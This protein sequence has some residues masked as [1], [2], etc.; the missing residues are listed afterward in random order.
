MRKA[1][2]PKG[3]PAGLLLLATS[4]FVTTAAYAQAWLPDKGRG[5]I[6]VGYQYAHAHWELLPIDLTDWTF[7]P[8]PCGPGKKC[9]DG[10]HYGQFVTFDVDYGIRQGLAMTAQLTW[11]ATQYK[12][13]AI[14]YV[15]GQTSLPTDNGNYHG[16]FQD[17]ELGVH[18]MVLRAPF[19]ATPFLAYHFPVQRYASLGHAA[20]GHH[21]RELRLGAA[22]ARTLTPFLPDV[23]VQ[24]TYAYNAAERENHHSLHRNSLDM[25]LGYFV[26]SKLSLKGAA[27]W[28]RTSGGIEGLSE[29]F[30]NHLIS[31]DPLANERTWRVGGGAAY[32]LTPRYDLYMLAFTTV[33][34]ENT[35]GMS[36]FAT[37]VGWNFATPWARLNPVTIGKTDP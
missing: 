28:L 6:Y 3:W 20:A 25:E 26:T 37:G 31:H 27:S 21:L 7:G 34:G 5:S 4:I 29:D 16:T 30:F 1:A 22:L 23:Y 36:A 8:Y 24:M 9:F 19:V 15:D 35:T 10:D 18:Q 11:V 13:L 32:A 2:F 17:A 14:K 33:S 12:G